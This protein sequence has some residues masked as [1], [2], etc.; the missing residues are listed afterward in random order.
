[1]FFASPLIGLAFGIVARELIKRFTTPTKLNIDIQIIITLVCGY[2]SFYVAEGPC[3]VSGVL[4]CITA[5][6]TLAL[7]VTPKILM[8]EKMHEVWSVIEWICNTLIFLLGGLIGGSHS[9]GTVT[10]RSI[11]YLLLMYVMLIGT[12]MIMVTVFF[13]AIST[14]GLKCSW[15]EAKFV[16]FAGLRG[17]LSIALALVAASEAV[18]DDDTDQNVGNQIFFMVT[19]LVSLTLIFNGSTAGWVLLRMKLVDDPSAPPSA[20]LSQVLERIKSF[21]TREVREELESMKTELGDYDEKEVERLCRLMD[22]TS[23]FDV[24]IPRSSTEGDKDKGPRNEWGLEYSAESRLHKQQHKHQQDSDRDSRDAS[25]RGSDE[26]GDEE[27][28]ARNFHSVHLSR[29]SGT[30]D[31][32]ND[33]VAYTRHT[34]CEVLRAR[35]IESIEMGRIGSSNSAA[36]LLLYSVDVSMDHVKRSLCDFP[37]IESFLK[38][39]RHIL[40]LCQLID[41]FFH[42]TIQVYPG[43]VSKLDAKAERVAIYTLIN[44]IDAHEYA[45]SQI[46]HFLGGPKENSNEFDI[47]QPEEAQIEKARY[48]LR[49]IAIEDVRKVYTH[50]AAK[51]IVLKQ[52]EMLHRMVSEGSLSE[53]NARHLFKTIEDDRDRIDI[54]RESH[55][56]SFVK[57]TKTRKVAEEKEMRESFAIRQSAVSL[58][59]VATG[60][61]GSEVVAPIQ[62]I[63]SSVSTSGTSGRVGPSGVASPPIGSPST[64]P[65]RSL[66]ENL[67]GED[68]L[69]RVS[70]HGRGSSFSVK[71]TGEGG[72][73]V[74]F[75]SSLGGL[76]RMPS[77]NNTVDYDSRAAQQQGRLESSPVVVSNPMIDDGSV[78]DGEMDEDDV[79]NSNSK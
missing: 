22:T 74:G 35:Y 4:S 36:K 45:L 59:D 28:Q 5:G 6:V 3:K 75:I 66:R 54:E 72:G 57:E 12:R 33:L 14:I 44:Y 2:G 68:D 15:T 62:P 79:D 42:Y 29:A 11:C 25:E 26:S 53:K 16:G 58:S 50:R 27:N 60:T 8:H 48:L 47:A 43:F 56:R 1:M 10:V 40:R 32:D 61:R 19:G 63:S 49:T 31:I 18:S 37:S 46:H 41:D 20:Q 9:A 23:E 77:I 76:R 38:P 24:L 39:S 69:D 51:V 64:P 13:P 70:Q 71:P 65:R 78:D 7:F 73:G 67:T 52:A 55:D 21:L 34:F 30:M 17:A